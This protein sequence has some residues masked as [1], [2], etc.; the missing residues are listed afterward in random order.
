MG[1]GAFMKSVLGHGGKRVRTGTEKGRKREQE[2]KKQDAGSGA[3]RR[4]VRA[5]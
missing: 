4:M 3:W 5:R 2:R 1:G